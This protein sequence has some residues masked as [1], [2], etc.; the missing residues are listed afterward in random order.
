MSMR[1]CGS[2]LSPPYTNMIQFSNPITMSGKNNIS[3]DGNDLSAFVLIHLLSLS[4]TLCT[5]T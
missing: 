5:V 1:T 4:I 2:P 3:Y